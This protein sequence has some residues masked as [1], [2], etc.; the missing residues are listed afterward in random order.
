MGSL[1]QVRQ[2]TF[3]LWRSSIGGYWFL[4]MSSKIG[5]MPEPSRHEGLGSV[6]GVDRPTAAHNTPR[7]D[8]EHARRV[9]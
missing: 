1:L 3:I 4:E 8:A 9:G 6:V 2:I 5:P 7:P